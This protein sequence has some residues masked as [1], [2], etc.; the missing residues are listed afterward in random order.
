LG[1]DRAVEV[2]AEVA[3]VVPGREAAVEVVGDGNGTMEVVGV[4]ALYLMRNQ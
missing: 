4:R 1:N 3:G 2:V